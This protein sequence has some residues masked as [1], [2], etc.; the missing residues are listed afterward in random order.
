MQ[1]A[2]EEQR[3][4]LFL[5]K[6]EMGR[7]SRRD[8][9]LLTMAGLVAGCGSQ[10]P[11]QLSGG[12]PTPATSPTAPVLR[13]R[14]LISAANARQLKQ[15]ATLQANTGR[16][17]GLAWSPDG[18]MLAV[19]AVGVVQFWEA[20]TGRQI[21]SLRLPATDT[22]A[23]Q[24]AW[25]PDGMLLASGDDN[26]AVRVW[27][28]Q[29][30]AVQQVLRG[31]S[32]VVLSLAW[33]PDGARLAAGSDSD[34]VQIWE[35]ATWAHPLLL[36]GP[37]T[38]GRYRAGRYREGVYGVAWSPDGKRL[39]AGRYDGF[40]R[41]WNVDSGQLLQ[42]L[43]PSNQPNGASWAPGGHVFATSSDDGTVQ[44]WDAQTYTNVQTLQAVD[45]EGASWAYAIPWS[46][47]GSLLAVSRDVAIV[48]VYEVASGKELAVLHGHN[49]SIWT[50]AWSPDS[51]RLASGSDDGTV[52]LWGVQ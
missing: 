45:Q 43:V 23:Y 21:A 34:T 27:D 25:S 42:T 4:D 11:S 16:V 28:V 3:K 18:K 24:L 31:P 8:M 26:N 39:V 20:A 15:L 22:Q 49:E 48:Q 1:D 5:S 35:R 13:P 17:R 9:L 2:S 37:G 32:S 7:I 14:A 30:R 44:V 51:L 12:L 50:A 41:V 19:G 6:N 29:K 10:T 52:C 38:P 47:D 40:V 46:P 36:S 33:S